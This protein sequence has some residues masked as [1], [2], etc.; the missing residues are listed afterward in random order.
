MPST[1]RLTLDPNSTARAPNNPHQRRGPS[2]T[3]ATPLPCPRNPRPQHPRQPPQPLSYNPDVPPG[4]A[5]QTA[6]WHDRDD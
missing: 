6:R 3:D 4:H 2:L 1:K 5:R